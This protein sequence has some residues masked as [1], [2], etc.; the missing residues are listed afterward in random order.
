MK[1]FPCFI[2]STP[3]G[4]RSLEI[5]A[6]T[7]SWMLPSSRISCLLAARFA[8]GYRRANAAA[9]SGSGA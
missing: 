9:R 8:C 6:D 5:A 3:S 1:S 7:T 2:T 4:A